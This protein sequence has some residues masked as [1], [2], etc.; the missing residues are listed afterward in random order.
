MTFRFHFSLFNLYLA[1]WHINCMYIRQY[2]D[3]NCIVNIDDDDV[4]DDDDAKV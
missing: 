3:K 2:E 4:D 1:C